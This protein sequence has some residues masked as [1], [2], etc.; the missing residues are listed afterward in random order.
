MKLTTVQSSIWQVRSLLTTPLLRV[1]ETLVFSLL[2]ENS[3]RAIN[4][5]GKNVRTVMSFCTLVCCFVFHSVKAA[6]ETA[7]SCVWGPFL[8]LLPHLAQPRECVVLKQVCEGERDLRGVDG[9]LTVTD[10]ES[11][12]STFSVCTP[13]FALHTANRELQK[14]VSLWSVC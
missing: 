3:P 1:I 14:S 5:F 12:N 9:T 2:N 10:P 6:L 4:E 11:L 8:G 13:D 7:G